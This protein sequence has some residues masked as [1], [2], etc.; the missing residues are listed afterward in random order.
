MNHKRFNSLAFLGALILAYALAGCS[1]FG[2]DND[3][4]KSG[5]LPP[6]EVPPDLTKPD[7]SNRMSIPGEEAGRISAVEASRGENQDQTAGVVTEVSKSSV[8]PEFM[9]IQVRREGN[10]RSTLR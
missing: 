7:W 9:G 2:S 10:V 4:T 5:S 8:L 1:I 3:Y 6:L